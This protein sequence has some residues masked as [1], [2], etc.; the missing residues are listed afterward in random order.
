MF[1]IRF[2]NYEGDEVEKLWEFGFRID[3]KSIK[4]SS[5]FAKGEDKLT[6]DA[7]VGDKASNV[8]KVFFTDIYKAILYEG[9]TVVWVGIR[10]KTNPTYNEDQQ[11]LSLTFVGY[12]DIL[13]TRKIAKTWVDNEAVN[14]L[15]TPDNRLDSSDQQNGTYTLEKNLLSVEIAKRVRDLYFGKRYHYLE[16]ITPDFLTTI[17]SVSGEISQRSGEGLC[18]E[19]LHGGTGGMSTKIDLAVTG[20]QTGGPSLTPVRTTF[21]NPL[22]DILLFPTNRMLCVCGTSIQTDTF[23]QWGEKDTILPIV[24]KAP[25]SINTFVYPF[26]KK[27]YVQEIVSITVSISISGLGVLTV[28]SKGAVYDNDGNYIDE[29][30]NTVDIVG[31]TPIDRVYSKTGGVAYGL[32]DDKPFYFVL[33]F[34]DGPLPFGT[35]AHLYGK[36]TASEGLETADR[37]Q[38]KDFTTSYPTFEDPLPSGGT[39]SYNWIKV[40]KKNSGTEDRY[41]QD[42]TTKILSLNVHSS[43]EITHSKYGIETFVGIELLEDIFQKEAA[44]IEFNASE[45]PTGINDDLPFDVFGITQPKPLIEALHKI[46]SVYSGGELFPAVW[47]YNNGSVPKFHLRLKDNT[48]TG[49]VYKIDTNNENVEIDIKNDT[50]IIN[51][52]HIHLMKNEDDISLNV[53]PTTYPQLKDD[54]SINS[55]YGRRPYSFIADELT[56]EEALRVGEGIVQSSKDPK[57]TG[58]ITITGDLSLMDN[59]NGAILSISQIKAGDKLRLLNYEDEFGAKNPIYQVMRTDYEVGRQRCKIYLDEKTKLELKLKNLKKFNESNK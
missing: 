33:F 10:S 19:I 36:S 4:Y 18:F 41:N 44:F 53:D 22:P 27:T 2:F 24:V 59:L 48:D 5:A 9:I 16:Y 37:T 14:R 8:K 56:L 58:T 21:N 17:K 43:Y 25:G 49:T 12:Y 47:A 57:P 28:P 29:F 26:Y 40:I 51:Y 20:D 54:D 15:F 30:T 11:K 3:Q 35:L 52:V 13:E 7:Y 45:M 50:S 55:P 42:D 1:T 46:Y 39:T 32:T 38:Y 34:D 23:I 31:A 6:F